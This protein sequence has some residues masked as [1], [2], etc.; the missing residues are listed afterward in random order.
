MIIENILQQKQKKQLIIPN[1]DLRKSLTLNHDQ[2]NPNKKGNILI[3]EY[4]MIKS[5]DLGIFWN[6]NKQ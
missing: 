5:Q 3:F 4:K 1:C 2:Q 6:L